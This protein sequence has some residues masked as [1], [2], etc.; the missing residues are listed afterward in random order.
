MNIALYPSS[1]L[2]LSPQRTT[3]TLYFWRCFASSTFFKCPLKIWRCLTESKLACVPGHTENSPH[4]LLRRCGPYVVAS[5]FR[6]FLYFLNL[7]LPHWHQLKLQLPDF[8]LGCHSSQCKESR[9]SVFFQF[10]TS[11]RN[12]LEAISVI[13]QYIVDSSDAA[14][15]LQFVI[16]FCHSATYLWRLLFLVPFRRRDSLSGMLLCF[17]NLPVLHR[18]QWKLH[19]PEVSLGCRPSP[20]TA[21]REQCRC[22]QL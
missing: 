3:H 19:L 17:Q 14:C 1:S 21:L 16:F 7:T 8:L 18:R 10:Q 12:H 4:I 22:C 9:S 15:C 13:G 11:V 20:C 6:M 5:L 2:T